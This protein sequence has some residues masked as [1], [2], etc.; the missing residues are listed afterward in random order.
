MMVIRGLN[1]ATK[2]VLME[3]LCYN[4]KKYMKFQGKKAL[5]AAESLSLN[6]KSTFSG[7]FEAIQGLLSA[8]HFQ[9]V[10]ADP[11]FT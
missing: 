4:L 3:A 2:H 7:F 6:G 8:V 10:S 5:I 11:K 1:Q 9:L